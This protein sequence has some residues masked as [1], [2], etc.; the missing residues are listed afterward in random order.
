MNK[1]LKLFFFFS[2]ILIYL[3]AVLSIFFLVVESEIVYMISVIFGY[4][5]ASIKI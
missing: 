1:N 2:K 4:I 3:F 5:K